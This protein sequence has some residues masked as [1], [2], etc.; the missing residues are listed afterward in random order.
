[1]FAQACPRDTEAGAMPATQT[2][3]PSSIESKHPGEIIYACP[4]GLGVADLVSAKLREASTA[5]GT[6]QKRAHSTCPRFKVK[7][8]WLPATSGRHGASCSLAI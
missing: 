5:P 8:G 6:S 2:T 1:M 4:Q 7:W 3:C